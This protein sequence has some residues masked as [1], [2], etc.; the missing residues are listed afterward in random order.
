MSRIKAIIVVVLLVGGAGAGALYGLNQFHQK[1]VT[2]QIEERLADAGK[3]V[4]D[5]LRVKAF[6]SI[7]NLSSQAKNDKLST[8]V[9]RL[10]NITPEMTAEE[11]SAAL[12]GANESLLPLLETIQKRIKTNKLLVLSVLILS[13]KMNRVILSSLKTSLEK[14]TMT[15][16]GKS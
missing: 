4:L 13:L 1:R 12:K 14:A 10:G 15:I 6:V 11:V 2:S 8:P 3:D 7:Q 16:L 5:R 9:G